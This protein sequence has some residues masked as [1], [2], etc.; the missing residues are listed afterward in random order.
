[1]KL[2][3]DSRDE[4]RKSVEILLNASPK[5]KKIQLPKET[6]DMLL[7]DTYTCNKEKGIKIKLP[8][9][10]GE[11][12]QKLDLIQVDFEDVSWILMYD[13][14]NAEFD[15]LERYCGL[16]KIFDTDFFSKVGKL[17]FSPV[18]YDYLIDY[19][20]TNARID[21][22][23]SFEYK[24]LE[25]LE[26]G[27][28]V[29]NNVDLSNNDFN[30]FDV[31]SFQESSF[32]NTHIK[33][34][35]TDNDDFSFEFCDFSNNDLSDFSF[36]GVRSICVG[37][38]ITGCDFKNTGAQIQFD[39]NYLKFQLERKGDNVEYKSNIVNTLRDSMR[40]MWIGCYLN[41]RKILSKEE[42][43][44]SAKE[45]REKYLE[46]KDDEISKVL[47]DI[48]EQINFSHSRR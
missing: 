47:D 48:S 44:Q 1:M 26:I 4:L 30:S 32:R 16:K 10:S 17:D 45:L 7:F 46:F 18:K 38:N 19:S 28:C 6:L 20:N 9:W 34:L 22:S 14:Y 37:D 39:K 5:N 36:D 41:G 27:G 12:L 3:K 33:L 23:K 8:V 29:F 21:F 35:L 25:C 24:Y 13:V 43:Q 40:E 42:K 31:L 2:N 11:F 15:E